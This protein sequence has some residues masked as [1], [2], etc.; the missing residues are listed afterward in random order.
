ML[1]IFS[2]Q[3]IKRY[4]IGD[5]CLNHARLSRHLP[6]PTTVEWIWVQWQWDLFRLWSWCPLKIGNIFLCIE[7]GFFF[8]STYAA[9]HQVDPA[10]EPLKSVGG[11]GTSI[12]AFFQPL[13]SARRLL[14][15]RE[16]GGDDQQKGGVLFLHRDFWTLEVTPARATLNKGIE[17]LL[18]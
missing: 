16:G 5:Q 10:K 12:C 1:L 14:S 11:R 18:G 4:Q 13:G 15:L 6:V 8:C 2:W 9:V 17:E 7:W 3:Y